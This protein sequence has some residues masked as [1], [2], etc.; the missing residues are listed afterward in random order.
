[1]KDSKRLD[2][3]LIDEIAILCHTRNEFNYRR[4]RAIHKLRGI[5]AVMEK[6]KAKKTVKDIGD[7]DVRMH[8]AM[9]SLTA[10]RQDIMSVPSSL[11]NWDRK[12]HFEN[13]HDMMTGYINHVRRDMENINL[14]A[15]TSKVMPKYDKMSI[16]ALR[17]AHEQAM[18]E[19]YAATAAKKKYVMAT[20]KRLRHLIKEYNLKVWVNTSNTIDLVCYK[21]KYE[22]L[23]LDN[24]KT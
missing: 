23:G 22:R 13:L 7:L 21:I 1:M 14:L 2:D 11:L 4:R 5:S 18:S 15:K 19:K 20:T 12:T 10:I 9:H 6:R 3:K 8:A 17:A 24:T 16:T